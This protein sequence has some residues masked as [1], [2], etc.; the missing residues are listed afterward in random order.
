ME[1]KMEKSREE[2]QSSKSS[3]AVSE[4]H[5]GGV[6]GPLILSSRWPLASCKYSIILMTAFEGFGSA[7]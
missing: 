1:D 7:R 2:E 4:V 5:P 3:S 6:K